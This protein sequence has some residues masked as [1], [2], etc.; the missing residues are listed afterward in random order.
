MKKSNKTYIDAYKN[1][2]KDICQN[3]NSGYNQMV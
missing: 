3:V 2:W 1:V